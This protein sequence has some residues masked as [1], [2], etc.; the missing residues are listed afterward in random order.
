[1]MLSSQWNGPNLRTERD[2]PLNYTPDMPVSVLPGIST[3]R[4]KLFWRL[5]IHTLA[6]LVTYYP[7]SYEFR[8]NCKPADQA[9]PGE[10]SSFLLRIDRS[11]TDIRL[12]KG[13]RS[14]TMQKVTAND[15]TGEIRLTFFNQS[16]LKDVFTTGRMFRFYGRVSGTLHA[17]E[18]I[19]PAYEPVMKTVD[20]NDYVPIYPLTAGL[21]DKLVAN[22]VR[23][24]LS[25]FQ[26]AQYDR[27]ARE[28]KERYKLIDYYEALVRI[29]FPKK[30]QD[31]AEARHRLAFEELLIFQYRLLALAN[32]EKR[33]NAYRLYYPDMKEFTRELP[34]S[35]T[36]DQKL[37]IQAVLVDMTGTA[38]PNLPGLDASTALPGLPPIPPARRLIQGDVGC[39]KT[40]V[41]AACIFACA[42]N[43]KQSALMAPT[44]ILAEQHYATLGPLFLRFGFT[45]A[46]LT[47]STRPAEKKKI[48][49]QLSVGEIDLIIGTHTLIEDAVQFYSLG[50]IITDEQ[51]RFGVKQR[52]SLQDKVGLADGAENGRK[53]HM[54]VMSATPIPRTLAMILYGDMELSVIH[55][56]PPGRQRIDT[57]AVG[58][59]MRDRIYRFIQKQVAAGAQGYIVC[60]LVQD[61]EEHPQYDT[62]RA[63]MKAAE[64]Y[65]KKLSQDI[66][67]DLRIEVIHGKQKQADKERV[68]RD[69]IEGNIDILV[70]T[71]VIEV[72]VNVPNASFMIVENAER[73]GLSQLHQLRGRVGRGEKKSF[74][75]LLSPLLEKGRPDSVFRQR[76]DVMC[77]TN[78]GFAIA[79]KDLSLRGPGEF[80]GKR[81]HGELSFK[82]ADVASDM[83]LLTQTKA[84]AQ[85]LLSSHLPEP[86]T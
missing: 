3:A 22:A 68:M 12:P 52:Q 48:L 28:V 41:A 36:H 34:Y 18:M 75:I 6:D 33:G 67:P 19:S 81:Q 29:H 50:L 86:L 2:E 8:G 5:D 39:G 69:F 44:G 53:P 73:F 26:D 11:V 64:S 59:G 7:R 63:E 21:T 47:G 46:L 60:P 37:A 4:E 31:I 10:V 66:F 72:G 14:K 70:S 80:F 85:E 49:R 58:E 76:M 74:C 15:E 42:K 27:L 35:L 38:R 40:I 23:N 83:E 20:L 51:H 55:E 45:V 9:I 78:D 79:E 84:L 61:Q 1:M 57:F 56:L 32:H 13:T 17:P 54:I 82:I 71:T 43:K 62:R 30:E 65:A 77:Q 16:Y 25:A 24:A